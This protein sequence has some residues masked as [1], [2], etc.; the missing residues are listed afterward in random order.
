MATDPKIPVRSPSPAE[1]RRP[2]KVSD[3]PEAG[4]QPT[5]TIRDFDKTGIYQ[6][7]VAADSAE[8]VD[9][10]EKQI[11]L[12]D[13]IQRV[14]LLQ[15]LPETALFF[16]EKELKF[17]RHE[18]KDVIREISKRAHFENMYLVV[19]GQLMVLGEEGPGRTRVVNI[20]KK[21]EFFFDR[22]F[23]W[24]G[25]PAVQVSAVMPS[26]VITIPAETLNKIAKVSAGVRKRLKAVSLRMDKR[27][28]RFDGQIGRIWNYL[29]RNGYSYS[30]RVRVIRLDKCIDCDACYQGCEKRWGQ[31]RIWKSKN[32]FGLLMFP[33]ACR[34]CEYTHCTAHCPGDHIYFDENFREVVIKDTC[35][36][37]TNCANDCPYGVIKMVER[38]DGT[39]KAEVGAEEVDGDGE[40]KK[41]KK[42]GKDEDD[43]PKS[44]K[45]K[46]MAIKCDHCFGYEDMACVTPCPTAA[47]FDLS[48][49]ELFERVDLY[50]VT[51]EEAADV[52]ATFRPVYN[53][54]KPGDRSWL[55]AMLWSVSLVSAAI[56]GW[57]HWSRLHH[58]DWSLSFKIARAL[59][60]TE[61]I[62]FIEAKTGLGRWE[63][64]IGS[65]L[66]SGTLIYVPRKRL[67]RIFRR[68]GSL[69]AFLD[70]HVFMGLLGFVF[71]TY[72][73]TF[74]I[75]FDANI[76]KYVLYSCALV[77]ATGIVGRYFYGQMPRTIA[78]QEMRLEDA[79][80]EAFQIEQQLKGLLGDSDRSKP[81]LDWGMPE[82]ARQRGLIGTVFT[83]I[84]LD[85][86]RNARLA[87][88][89]RRLKKLGKKPSE[90]KGIVDT[91]KRKAGLE[92]RILLYEKSQ[93]IARVWLAIH[94]VAATIMFSVLAWHIY[95]GL[96]FSGWIGERWI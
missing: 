30:E 14:P 73:T 6:Q 24:A 57:E 81:F 31:A 67:D 37:C 45:K 94:I 95:I 64:W 84:A 87:G 25:I 63:G 83:M 38:E 49:R 48:Q 43:A 3:D 74:E 72:H 26:Q 65:L 78:G 1:R 66:L 13:A 50:G 28:E 93:K 21:G 16:L 58:V 53:E 70:V 62:I 7:I 86:R 41:G 19:E 60:Y 85:F 88:L 4:V 33:D 89:S 42:K 44:D 17:K 75:G 92:Q 36:G 55:Q 10:L 76:F 39:K 32:K 22:Q 79:K 46:Q 52:A 59:G 35:T 56:L 61:E 15:T 11:E 8:E 34:T 2:P 80:A 47:I 9:A 20:L 68:F 23:N 96:K 5:S 18:P 90:I 40:P 51:G 29:V 12:I 27:A 91:I 77:V 71:A 54:V 69:S 82:E